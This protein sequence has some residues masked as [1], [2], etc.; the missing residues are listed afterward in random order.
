M[1][2]E[3]AQDPLAIFGSQA[4]DFPLPTNGCGSKNRYQN[5]TLVSGN[6]AKTCGLPPRSFNLEPHP[7]GYPPKKVSLKEHLQGQ[8]GQLTWNLT[9]SWKTKGTLCQIPREKRGRVAF[10]RATSKQVTK[11]LQ[12]CGKWHRGFQQK[13]PKD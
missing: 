12:G 1:M 8:K 6:L 5:G 13:G 11:D 2:I 7:N 4:Y 10:K 3:P 9:G